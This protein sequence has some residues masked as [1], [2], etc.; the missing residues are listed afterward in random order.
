[1]SLKSLPAA[2]VSQQAFLANF[3]NSSEATSINLKDFM[4]TSKL[5]V[6]LDLQR[7]EKR[8]PKSFALFGS[9]WHPAVLSVRFLSGPVESSRCTLL[10]YFR[11]QANSFQ[12]STDLILPVEYVQSEKQAISWKKLKGFIISIKLET[13]IWK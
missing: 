3:L 9:K 5:K 6:Q 7:I 4:R 12:L 11:S 10:L 13:Q 8:N 2:C 1:M